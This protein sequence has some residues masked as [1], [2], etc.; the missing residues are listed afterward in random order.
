[1]FSLRN[2]TIATLLLSIN[3]LAQ[4]THAPA[5]NV[6]TVQITPSTQEAEVGQK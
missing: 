6:K 4:S 2:A 5:S 1:M 3:V